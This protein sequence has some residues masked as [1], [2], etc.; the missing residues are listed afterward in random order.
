MAQFLVPKQHR[1]GKLNPK[2]RWGLHLGV[3]EES[4]GWELLDLT[5][6]RVVTTSDMVFYETKSL[7]AGEPCDED[8]EDVLPPSSSPTPPVPPLVANLPVLTLT[9]ASGDEGS[10]RASLPMAPG[11]G[12]TG[13]RRDVKHAGV[14]DKPPRTE[15]Q[16]AEEVP[17]NLVEPAKEASARKPPTGEQ[18]PTKP[19]R[20]QSTSGQ[21]AGEPTTG[22][23]SARSTPKSLDRDVHADFRRPPKFLTY[24]VCLPPAVFSTV[25][26]DP[27]DDLLYDDAEDDVDLPELD[28]GMHADPEHCW[29]IATMMVKEVL[30]SWKGKAVKAA[31]DEEIRSL[32]GM[33][34]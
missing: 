32:I 8:A 4:K 25:Y 22:E 33:G 23:Q 27:D 34:T 7:E 26:D 16:Q 17:P 3:S 13:G 18:P 5:N 29:D 11:K 2:A 28:R 20:E 14:G 21:P 19:T 12:I 6:N 31:V 10:T 24:H 9:S 1:G 15:E 30:A